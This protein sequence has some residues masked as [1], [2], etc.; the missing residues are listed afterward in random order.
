[1]SSETP[2]FDTGQIG[3]LRDILQKFLPLKQSIGDFVRFRIVVD[4]NFVIRELTQHVKYPERG[5]TALEELMRATLVDAYA[6]RWLETEIKSVIPRVAAKRKISEIAL[7]EQW[8]K[9]RPL[10]KWDETLCEPASGGIR[11]HDPKDMPYLALEKKLSADG[12]L[13]EDKDIGQ[14]GGHALTLDFVL[15]VRSYARAAVVTVSIRVFGIL[16]TTV[17][18]MA[19]AE[20]FGKIGRSIAALPNPVKVMLLIAA[21]FVLLHSGSRKWIA[22]RCSDIGSVIAPMWDDLSELLL[23]AAKMH[24]DSLAQANSH[25]AVATSAARPKQQ[26]TTRVRRTRRRHEGTKLSA[27]PTLSGRI[28]A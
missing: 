12:I 20:L 16:L 6:P 17:A 21:I 27:K 7:W 11:E 22:E 3:P 13:S 9:Y 26:R 14:M 23:M 25:L 24:V 2:R 19:L 5:R 28:T 1:M 15:S 18:I 8:E 10:L 4:A